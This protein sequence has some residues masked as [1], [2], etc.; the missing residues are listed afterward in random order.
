MQDTKERKILNQIKEKLR[1]NNATT[2][3]ADK[4]NSIVILAKDSY[5]NK[6]QTFINKNNFTSTDKDYTN[7][8]QKDIR[9][10]INDCP[11]LIHKDWQLVNLNPSL[12]NIR[13]ALS[14]STK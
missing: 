5:H 9:N 14:T 13:E 4:G 10:T 3:K 11:N 7:K 8:Y 12:P 1:S 6:I 2:L